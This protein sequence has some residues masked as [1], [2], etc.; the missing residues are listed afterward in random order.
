MSLTWNSSVLKDISDT[1][2]ARLDLAGKHLVNAIKMNIDIQG[3]PTSE[4]GEFPHKDTGALQ[5]GVTYEVQPGKLSLTADVD[6]AQDL[7]FGT[8]RA[9]AR[10]FIRPTLALEADAVNKIIKGGT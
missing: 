1:M 6:Y 9:A 2:Q 7:E 8:S 5:A 10:P 3:P 4:P